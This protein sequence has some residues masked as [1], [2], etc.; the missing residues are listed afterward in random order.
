MKTYHCLLIF[1]NVIY[2]TNGEGTW[3]HPG[4][5]KSISNHHLRELEKIAKVTQNTDTNGTRVGTNQTRIAKSYVRLNSRMGRNEDIQS[6]KAKDESEVNN[7]VS[8]EE[9]KTNRNNT[10]T[11]KEKEASTYNFYPSRRDATGKRKQQAVRNDNKFNFF[12]TN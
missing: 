4:M 7:F 11:A 12:F 6:D 2:L 5:G 1:I 3:T 9:E 10:Q 8:D